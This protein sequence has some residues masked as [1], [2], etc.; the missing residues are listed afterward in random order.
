MSAHQFKVFRG[1]PS[2]GIIETVTQRPALV[3]DQVLISVTHS[4]VCGT[5]EHYLRSGIA[6]G[7]EGVGIVKQLGPDVKKLKISESCLHLIPDGLSSAAAAPL[8]C[9]GIT[10]W[11]ALVQYG[12]KPNDTVGIVGIGGL[13]HLAIQ[14]AKSMGCEVVVF[15][16][17]DSKKEQAMNLGASYFVSTRNRSELSVPKKVNQLLVTTSQDP[18]WDL[19]MPI[20]ANDASI[21]PMAAL[22][23]EAK[24][25]IPYMMCL[26]KGIRVIFSLP[27]MLSYRTMLD[28][29]A[30]NGISPIIDRDE[31]TAEG[32]VKSLEKLSTGKTRYRGVLYAVEE[33]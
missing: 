26:M 9:G 17:T 23:F 22:D 33:D 3:K 1:T 4:G 7:H 2:G 12:V 27:S 20:M 32:I 14:F 21:F 13:G 25:G 15:S 19:L 29:A 24:L 16:T 11:A 8:M 18:D 30:R 31:L 5:D 10:V 28:F 6:L